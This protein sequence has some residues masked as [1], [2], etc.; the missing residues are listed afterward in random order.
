[1]RK[2]KR[3]KKKIIAKLPTILWNVAYDQ[4]TATPVD[5]SEPVVKILNNVN[6]DR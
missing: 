6:N 2:R 4:L 3:D 5:T 1:M